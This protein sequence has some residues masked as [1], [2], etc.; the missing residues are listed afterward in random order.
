[1][2]LIRIYLTLIL[3]WILGTHMIVVSPSA[4]HWPLARVSNSRFEALN[5]LSTYTSSH[6]PRAYYLSVHFSNVYNCYS[7]RHFSFEY[8]QK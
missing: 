6:E 1:V 3:E 5:A 7:N 2:Y 4:K 8:F